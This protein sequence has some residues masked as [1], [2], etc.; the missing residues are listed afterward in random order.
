VRDFLEAYRYST[1]FVNANPAQAAVWIDEIGI[2]AAEI[3]EK[4]IPACNIT[5]IDGEEMRRLLS[6]FLAV[7]HAQN[8]QSIGGELP[9]DEF[10]WVG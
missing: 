3:A 6:G 8:P 4:A 2:A 9:G 5:Y 10:Y 7:L 1:Q